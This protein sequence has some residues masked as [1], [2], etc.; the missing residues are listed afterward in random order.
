MRYVTIA[1]TKIQVLEY[2]GKRVMTSAQVN[3]VMGVES[4]TL[5]YGK[6][7]KA[8]TDDFI[9]LPHCEGKKFLADNCLPGFISGKGIILWGESAVGLFA[10]YAC[11]SSV[12]RELREKYFNSDVQTYELVLVDENDNEIESDTLCVDS[13]ADIGIDD[14]MVDGRRLHAFLQVETR[15]NDWFERMK[16]YGF[17]E[18]VDFYSKM[19]KTSP[20]GGRPSINHDLTIDMAKEISMIQ[21]NERGKQARQ[22]FIECEKRLK[23]QTQKPMTQAELI[24]MQANALVEY[25]REQAKLKEDVKQ[26]KEQSEHSTRILQS[27]IDTLNGVCTEGTPRQK[28]KAMVD[29]YAIKNGLQFGTAWREFVTAYNTAYK[30][31]LKRKM[32]TYMRAH[33]IKKMTSPEYLEAVGKLDDAMRVA[34]K[35]LNPKTNVFSF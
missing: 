14:G 9:R 30:T 23:A 8:K 1:N 12:M 17:V 10:N 35:M 32:K 19:S 4:L 22:Y 28:L 33:G 2:E 6:S 26:I 24:A 34:D 21:R 18:G 29:L 5:N 15:Y 16:E 20:N 7:V 11:K 13:V 31:N 3:Q 25:E 27:R